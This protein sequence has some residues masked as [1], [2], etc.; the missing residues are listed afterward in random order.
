MESHFAIGDDG[1]AFLDAWILEEPLF[2]Q[3]AFDGHVGALGVAEVVL[4]GLFFDEAADF[5]E[6]LS[7]AFA[8]GEALHASEVFASELVEHAVRVHDIDRRQ[9]VALS[10]LEV[11]LVMRRRDFEHAGA[12]GEVHVL[13]RDDREEFLIFEWQRAA[14]V[15]ADEVGVALVLGIHGN[16][17]VSRDH[18]GAGGGDGEPGAGFFDDFDFEVVHDGVLRLHDDLLIAERGKGGGAPVHHALATIDEAFFVEVHKHAHDA[19]VVVGIEGEALAAPVAGGTEFLELL[20][21]DAAVLFLPF[22]DFGNEGFTAEVVAML[23]DTLLFE[24]LFDDVLR[25]DAGVVGTGEPEDFFPQHAGAAGED[26]L[27]GVVQDVAEREDAGDVGRGDDD[28][29]GRAGRAHTSG[30]GFK[31]F[32]VQPALIPAGFD[33]RGCVGLVEFGHKGRPRWGKAAALQTPRRF[34]MERWK[35]GRWAVGGERCVGFERVVFGKGVRGRSAEAWGQA[36][37]PGAGR[38][39]SSAYCD[40]LEPANASGVGRFGEGGGGS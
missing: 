10:D 27:D 15:L 30:V 3:S 40:A 31:A 34:R 36:S 8:C 33:F 14:D 7:G 19:G 29:V 12:E 35:G 23:D 28:G 38:A 24:G 17:L 9:I 1:L 11:G 26:V 18:F 22:P 5:R 4:I 13:I 16:G 32:V 20:D 21:D 2:A 25:G 6:Q 39:E 37:L